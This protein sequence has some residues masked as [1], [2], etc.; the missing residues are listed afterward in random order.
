MT[1]NR[2]LIAFFCY[3]FRALPAMSDNFSK[4]LRYDDSAPSNLVAVVAGYQSTRKHESGVEMSWFS[5]D[6]GAG[7]G[8]ETGILF[9]ILAPTNYAGHFFWV[10]RP[11]GYG[12]FEDQRMP[13][14]ELFRKDRLYSFSLANNNIVGML[15]SQSH[16]NPDDR[17]TTWHLGSSP[18]FWRRQDAF[19]FC[20]TNKIK[21][22]R[23]KDVLSELKRKLS[24]AKRREQSTGKKS[25]E[26]R[27]LAKAV[28]D[29]I[30]EI[31]N[32]ERNVQEAERQITRLSTMANDESQKN[33]AERKPVA[34]DS[35]NKDTNIE[36]IGTP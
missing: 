29:M 22:A 15:A 33:D 4:V 19:A 35:L 3:C 27:A 32:L 16:L 24:E 25:A 17:L 34:N 5:L 28:G 21:L 13:S 30:S 8:K 7:S 14:G 12:P 31:A 20:E 11:Q 18:Y 26:Q 23:C 6:P 10:E 36:T 2:V 9:Y 1:M